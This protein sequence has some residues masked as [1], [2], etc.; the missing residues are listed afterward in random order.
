MRYKDIS[1]SKFKGVVESPQMV[2][3]TNFDLDND[4]HNIKF[5]K[6]LLKRKVELIKDDS[7]YEVI[8]SGDDR[9]GNIALITKS[10]PPK[11]NYR[12]KYTTKHIKGIGNAV[13]QVLLWRNPRGIGTIGITSEIFFGYLL[14]KYPVVMSDKQ[15]TEDG[16]RFWETRLQEAIIKGYKIGLFNENTKGIIWFN[17]D[18]EDYEQ[19]LKDYNGWGNSIKHQNQRYIISN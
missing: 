16:R 12:V 18:Q 15:Q 2:G 11:I 13:T 6:E 10:D 17:G 5:A 19:W 7:R 9:N 4:D 3:N 1:S 8:R 14:N